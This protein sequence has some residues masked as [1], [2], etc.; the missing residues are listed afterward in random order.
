M[1]QEQSTESLI[2]YED[3]LCVVIKD[4]KHIATA[5]YQCI[6]KRHIRNFTKLVLT[7][8]PTGEQSP[9]LKLLKHMEAIG[10]KFLE[11]RHFG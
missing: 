4:T 6:P 9:D 5:H 3:A 7:E 10:K 2:L 11:T 1:S 8:S